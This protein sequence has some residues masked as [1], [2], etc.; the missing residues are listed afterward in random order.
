MD[1]KTKLKLSKVVDS[2]WDILPPEV[3][4][5]ILKW[6]EGQELIDWRESASSRALCHEIKMYKM[7]L[8]K[9]RI[10]HIQ[11]Q[12]IDFKLGEECKYMQIYGWYR[13]SHG[14]IRKFFLGVTIE[15]AIFG[16]DF[17]RAAAVVDQSVGFGH[18]LVNAFFNAVFL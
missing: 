8:V 3:K 1:N 18:N 4:E 6:K 7:L 9:W 10:G 2:Y 13:S 17:R 15:N 14:R 16:I 11:C 12:P 5:K